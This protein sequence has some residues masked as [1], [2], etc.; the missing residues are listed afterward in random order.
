MKDKGGRKKYAAT[1]KRNEIFRCKIV[2]FGNS[3]ANLVPVSRFA[4]STQAMRKSQ[5]TDCRNNNIKIVCAETERPGRKPAIKQTDMIYTITIDIKLFFGGN[6]C[7]SAG[8]QNGKQK[9][10]A[11][12]HSPPFEFDNRKHGKDL[13]LIQRTCVEFKIYHGCTCAHTC[14]EV[15]S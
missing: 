12:K 14:C 6:P 5:C 10:A 15:Q 13:L 1:E 3:G 7:H 9:T 8:Y 11:M 4:I 2:L